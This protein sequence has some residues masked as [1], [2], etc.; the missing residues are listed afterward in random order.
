MDAE[1][2]YRRLRIQLI[3]DLHIGRKRTGERLTSI[4][5]LARS[6]GLD[7]RLVASAYA[8]LEEEGLVNVRGRAGVFLCERRGSTR[9][10][11]EPE[12]SL[13]ER[14]AHDFALRR[15]PLPELVRHVADAVRAELNC[16]C[17][18]STEDHEVA[19]AAEME[20]NFGIVPRC[21]RIPESQSPRQNAALLRAVA[22]ADFVVTTA[23]HASDL[24][25]LAD[26]AGKP[27]VTMVVNSELAAAL[28]KLLESN[29]VT[30]VAADSALAGRAELYLRQSRH[31][32]R[33]R[34]LRYD[35]PAVMR[36]DPDDPG[37]VFTRAARRRLA[38]EEYHYRPDMPPF[39][40]AESIAAIARLIV[41]LNLKKARQI[42]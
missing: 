41:R 8:R 16:V 2:L 40:S 1:Q 19:I 30:V 36:L 28:S 6:T 20:H 35:D 15:V 25:A 42:S 21:V 23:F 38:L 24:S 14:L 7:H 26:N 13:L 10:F 22:N 34:V 39:F 3:G 31:A 12:D 5:E 27:L 4:R 9:G 17:M 33:F 32:D 18:E 11:P 29:L 37:V